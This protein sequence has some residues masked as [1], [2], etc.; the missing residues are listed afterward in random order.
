MTEKPMCFVSYSRNDLKK[1]IR[2]CNEFAKANIDVWFDKNDIVAGEAWKIALY[3]GVRKSDVLVFLMTPNSVQSQW[4]LVERCLAGF[5][6]TTVVT[7]L[8][9]KC[10][11]PVDIHH[12][13]Y[14]DLS[15]DAKANMPALISAIHLGAKQSQKDRQIRRST[16]QSSTFNT[17]QTGGG[18]TINV[19]TDRVDHIGRKVTKD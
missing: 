10:T 2:I 11:P 12:L 19:S 16:G 9:E 18:D 8:L 5:D 14:I 4:C 13:H 6:N 17:T 7:V 3:E 15:I 1:A